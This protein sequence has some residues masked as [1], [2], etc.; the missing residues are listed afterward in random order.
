MTSS[1]SSSLIL[2]QL[3]RLVPEVQIKFNRY[4]VVNSTGNRLLNFAGF[5]YL[6]HSCPSLFYRGGDEGQVAAL[7]TQI[8][9]TY[10]AGGGGG[11][12]GG[13]L[14]TTTTTTTTSSKSAKLTFDGFMSA[15]VSIAKE[16]FPEDA[17]IDNASNNLLEGDSSILEIE[18]SNENDDKQQTTI[19]LSKVCRD[20]KRCLL[21]LLSVHVLPAHADDPEITAVF[22][23]GVVK[24][25]K[26]ERLLKRVSSPMSFSS[27]SS[28]SSSSPL[29]SSRDN[30]M[31]INNISSSSSSSL[32]KSVSPSTTFVSTTT[33]PGGIGKDLIKSI[34]SSPIRD[35][36]TPPQP[37]LFSSFS[38]NASVPSLV[39]SSHPSN[40]NTTTKSELSST[41]PLVS[42]NTTT[43]SS[44]LSSSST[45]TT[46]AIN[47]SLIT[48][49]TAARLESFLPAFEALGVESIDDLKDLNEQDFD[50]LGMKE[51]H[52]RRL[53]E[54]LSTGKIASN[55][56]SPISLI[57]YSRE[58]SPLPPSSLPIFGQG[59]PTVV[60]SNNRDEKKDQMEQS[61]MLIQAT[62]EHAVKEAE[63]EHRFAQLE[64]RGAELK[65]SQLQQEALDQAAK[66]LD[67]AQLVHA[68]AYSPTSSSSS[69]NISSS[70]THSSNSTSSYEWEQYATP[71]GV[72]Y[73]YKP[74]TNTTQ[75]EPPP[76]GASVR[77]VAARQAEKEQLQIAVESK[78][79]Q[80][81]ETAQR[82]R[83]AAAA[84]IQRS[85][86]P[87]SLSKNS[88]SHGH[89]RLVSF[90]LD[91]APSSSS[92]SSSSSLSN[93]EESWRSAWSD[94]IETTAQADRLIR[95]VEGVI[96]EEQNEKQYSTH[97]SSTKQRGGVNIIKTKGPLKNAP[98]TVNS[99]TS[100]AF[101]QSNSASLNELNFYDQEEE[102]DN[103]ITKTG[104][105]SQS[106]HQIL[107]S[108]S[109]SSSSPSINSAQKLRNE[110]LAIIVPESATSSFSSN[111]LALTPAGLATPRNYAANQLARR[112]CAA[113]A[114]RE[115]GTADVSI[116]DAYADVF[117]ELPMMDS[118]TME[119]IARSHSI[120]NS[121]VMGYADPRPDLR[122]NSHFGVHADHAGSKLHLAT[123]VRGQ[124]GRSIQEFANGL[125]H[126]LYAP[127]TDP[128]T[129]RTALEMTSH[130][131]KSDSVAPSS[132][133]TGYAYRH[134]AAVSRWAGQ[135]TVIDRLTDTRGYTGAHKHRFDA[136][137]RGK[138]IAGRDS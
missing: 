19:Q 50:N 11:G 135:G 75:W 127:S 83:V 59:I 16:T 108:S 99:S 82:G 81:L 106:D 14:S 1:T 10:T 76:V 111:Y 34:S 48:L 26:V 103:K 65:V 60:E 69:S 138:G 4:S 8:S 40:S 85:S 89:A 132:A 97:T 68:A 17:T 136:D 46:T 41:L 45:T 2:S 31:N 90:A 116:A 100:R 3:Y 117:A 131:G 24:D 47:H 77:T 70:N 113:L 78:M 37:P 79:R 21:R 105:D 72:I 62:I 44:S 54:M 133:V 36:A 23:P 130:F 84:H 110:A 20:S 114:T 91:D 35:S 63:L 29:T 18:S 30:G 118:A 80:V 93:V 32:I 15:L 73:Y 53:R 49:V 94:V 102:D 61:R 58:S 42:S 13:S 67:E 7:F 71:E 92:S 98:M 87:S 9:A 95:Q 22:T 86:P 66:L 123:A 112:R 128:Y 33:T 57:G 38:N 5:K 96:E 122:P 51:L 12:Q 25:E 28:S 88:S 101:V 55:R 126:M 119:I 129:P 115:G 74:S 64:A 104:D 125:R 137:G 6:L 27:S 120:A 109:S 121:R 43:S 134:A 52:K 124:G 39:S 56:A 107:I